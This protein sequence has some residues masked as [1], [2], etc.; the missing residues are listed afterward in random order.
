MI[1]VALIGTANDLY[2]GGP[3][4]PPRSACRK[5]FG[6][7]GLLAAGCAVNHEGLTCT[8]YDG[9]ADHSLATTPARAP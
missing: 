5:T 3:W 6:P 1:C 8:T 9:I 2:R 4:K 7:S